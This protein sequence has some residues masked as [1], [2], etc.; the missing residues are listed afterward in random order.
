VNA[1]IVVVAFRS[2]PVERHKATVA[3][4]PFATSRGENQKRG[5]RPPSAADRPIQQR[6]QLGEVPLGGRLI[7]GGGVA[8][9]VAVGG[10]LVEL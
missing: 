7:V 3:D 10:P 2:R 8:H 5:G 9:R 1:S 6:E 4:C